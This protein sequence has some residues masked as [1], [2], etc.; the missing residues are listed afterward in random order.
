MKGEGRP[1]DGADVGSFA[2]HLRD[3]ARL[4]ALVDG[5]VVADSNTAIGEQ[6]VVLRLGGPY[7]LRAPG[8]RGRWTVPAS[9]DGA[10]VRKAY[11]KHQARMNILGAAADLANAFRDT[12]SPPPKSPS[13]TYAEPKVALRPYSREE[14]TTSILGASNLLA[15]ALAEHMQ[16]VDQLAA[17]L[18]VVKE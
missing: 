10:L 5:D 14:T 16:E 15:E 8:C 17:G 2:Q 18:P 13:R 3:P 12:F 7:D 11:T 4:L 1:L 9:P 6:E